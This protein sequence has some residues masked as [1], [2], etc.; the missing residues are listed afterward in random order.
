VVREEVVANHRG[1]MIDLGMVT[2]DGGRKILVRPIADGESDGGEAYV[3]VERLSDTPRDIATAESSIA[4][5][6][7][8]AHDV[9]DVYP[10]GIDADAPV[11]LRVARSPQ[12]ADD[13]DRRVGY[14]HAFALRT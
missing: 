8:Y 2:D 4:V 9:S 12:P 6:R 11:R 5:M 13:H 10:Q 14:F 1:H 7:N 3:H